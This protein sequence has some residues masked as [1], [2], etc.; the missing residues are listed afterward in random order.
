M[1]R[2][3]MLGLIAAVLAAVLMAIAGKSCVKDAKV[4]NQNTQ[5]PTI[6]VSPQIVQGDNDW[7]P[8]PDYTPPV[9]TAPAE[10]EPPE[11]AP[12]KETT[13]KS[14]LDELWEQTAK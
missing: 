5:R 2:N 9:Q 8:N 6:I 4:K 12:Q 1:E 7:T 10:T 11:E 14:K 13:S 3:K